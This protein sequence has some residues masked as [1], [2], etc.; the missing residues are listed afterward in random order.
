MILSGISAETTVLIAFGEILHFL[1][2][3]GRKWT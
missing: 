3:H 2:S 1:F